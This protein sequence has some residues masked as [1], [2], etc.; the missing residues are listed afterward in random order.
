MNWAV[1]KVNLSFKLKTALIGVFLVAILILLTKLFFPQHFIT[2]L[3]VWWLSLWVIVGQPFIEEY[4]FRHLIQK[5]ILQKMFPIQRKFKP[6][7]QYFYF[8]IILTAFVFSA[9]HFKAFPELAVVTYING[10]IYGF[11]YY[12]SDSLTIS[13]IAH[14][15]CNFLSLAL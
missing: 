13:W 12:Y 11:L 8:S 10:L 1:F 4:I 7:K 9:I 5:I 2:S 6:T 15:T 3:P 14:A